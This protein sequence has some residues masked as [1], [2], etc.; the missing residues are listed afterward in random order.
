[1]EIITETW[2]RVDRKFGA[3]LTMATYCNL[4]RVLPDGQCVPDD[5]GEPAKRVWGAIRGWLDERYSLVLLFADHDPAINPGEDPVS[6]QRRF[7][8]EFVRRFVFPNRVLPA[9]LENEDLLREV[10]RIYAL[11]REALMALIA[12]EI[13]RRESAFPS[14]T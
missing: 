6:G 8:V 13:W 2:T 12:L 7:V 3:V 10:Q 1:M 4:Y 14:R 9:R 5:R 11:Q